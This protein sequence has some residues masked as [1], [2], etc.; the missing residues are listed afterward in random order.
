[1]RELD[2]PFDPKQI[3]RKRKAYKRELKGDGT[4]RIGKNIAILGGSTTNDLVDILELFLLNYGIEPSFYQS[5]YGKFWED[6]VFDNPIL[7]GFNPDVIFI[8]T[9]NR[10]ITAYPAIGDNRNAAE[11][12]LAEQYGRF[13]TLW[14]SLTEKY[15]CP[16]I[17]NNFELPAARAM[18][19]MEASSHFGTVNFITRL[20][21]LFYDYADGHD[22][23]YINDINHQSAQLG[24]DRWHD[25]FAWYMYK[26]AV[27]LDAIPTLAFNVANII[28]AIYGKN[29]KA[30]ALDLDNTLWGGIVGDDGAEGLAVGNETSRGQM[31]TE[32][33]QYLKKLQ[34]CGILLNIISKNEES[35]AMAGLNNP[36]MVLKK[37]D[38]ISIKANWEPKSENLIHMA[39]ELDLGVDSLVFVDDN[40]AEREII[41]QQGLGAGI[42]K[43]EKPETYIRQIDRAGYFE[44]VSCSEDDARRN[45]M[46]RENAK[47]ADFKK[48]FTDYQEYLRSLAMTAQIAPFSSAYF[49]RIAQLTNKSN[50]FNLT[51]RRFTRDEIESMSENRGYVTLYGK[52]ADK[53]GDN[54]VVS[55]VIGKKKGKILDIILWLMSC[56]V[57]KRDMEFAMMDQLV[58]QCKK[59]EI[60]TIRGFYHPTEK[61]GMVK[62]FYAGQGF[63]KDSEDAKGNSV[64]SM[65]VAGYERKNYVIHKED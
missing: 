23:L 5:E 39:Q 16:I 50:Q 17:Q 21:V 6:G 19:N 35:N 7:D 52:L 64:W 14:D 41:R 22:Y 40:P 54:G 38:F 20:N 56:R 65:A 60:T 61:N 48:R 11:A 36:G 13:E 43:L 58:E 57:L 15:H 45:V 47:R 32:F 49:D 25:P 3:M 42:P 10:N 29:K 30:L 9:T 37:D 59:E 53:F 2:Y 44:M 46:Y 28:K 8:H 26:Y 24:F 51:T 27:S 31:Y 12:L 4:C 18:G 55:V 62:D 34:S 63:E 1:M 33:Q